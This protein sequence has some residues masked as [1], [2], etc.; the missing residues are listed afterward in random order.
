[1]TAAEN[2]V[3]GSFHASLSG[4]PCARAEH[5]PSLLIQRTIQ[6]LDVGLNGSR[7]HA[8]IL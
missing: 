1:M 7:R 6:T 4:S 3:A 2:S 5:L 8:K